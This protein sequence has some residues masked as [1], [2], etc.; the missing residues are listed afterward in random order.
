[1]KDCYEGRSPSTALES[2]YEPFQVFHLRSIDRVGTN[3]IKG[4]LNY[5]NTIASRVVEAEGGMQR[6]IRQ[7][8]ITRECGKLGEVSCSTAI[9]LDILKVTIYFRNSREES[10]QVPEQTHRNGNSFRIK[11]VLR[12]SSLLR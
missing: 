6:E 8:F 10:P 1:M 7:S 9:Q 5:I 3:I 11:L 4:K 2:A 12:F